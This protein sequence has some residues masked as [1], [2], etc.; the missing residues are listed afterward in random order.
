VEWLAAMA[1]L[2]E[3]L[4][5]AL[6]VRGRKATHIDAYLAERFQKKGAGEKGAGTGYVH[7]VLKKG[8][9]PGPDE[10]AAICDFLEIRIDWLVRG[11]GPMD[12]GR[13]PE[14]VATYDSIAGW[15][16]AADQEL[17]RGR[18]VQY[19]IRAAGRSPISV[20]PEVITPDFVFRAAMFWL[21][22]APESERMAA[23]KTEAQRL[24]AEEDASVARGKRRR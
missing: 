19:A 3:R 17:Q 10:L 9:Q 14:D 2:A 22:S 8:Q 21:E 4:A 23:M 24:Q 16:A 11:T 5:H 20:R 1:D 12:R 6:K 18:V 7:R 15:A 13:G